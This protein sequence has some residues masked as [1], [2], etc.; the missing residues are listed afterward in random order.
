MG[1]FLVFVPAVPYGV[2][3]L[4]SPGSATAPLPPRAD[5]VAH[6]GPDVTD[7]PSPLSA[8]AVRER[9]KGWEWK[10]LESSG[11]KILMAEHV[12]IRGDAPLEALRTS[13]A[14][15]EAYREMLRAGLGGDA[16]GI[17]FSLRV[18]ADPREFRAYASIL[19]APNAESLYD[20]RTQEV[21]ICHEPAKGP[22]WLRR[23]LAHEFTHAYMDRVFRRVEPL[24]LCEGLAEYFSNFEVL[25]GRLVPGRVD[26]RAVLLLSLEAPLPLARFLRLRR[27]EMYGP[28]FPSHYAQAWSLA[29]HLM[30]R[31]DGTMDLL[32][33]G[34][35]VQDL[36]ELEKDWKIHL[37]KLSE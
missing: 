36:E 14:Y 31:R 26:R 37:K 13:G 30:S 33:R 8:K 20:P 32:L 28:A 1:A 22:S 3:Q 16:E 11:W 5:D 2:L 29:H 9:S 25:E 21:V 15:L 23:T 24:W 18:F 7:G 4:A 19:G 17:M 34:D 10:P 12:A 35:P 6:A 27:D